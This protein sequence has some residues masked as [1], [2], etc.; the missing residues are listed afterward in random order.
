MTIHKGNLFVKNHIRKVLL[1]S[2]MGL[3]LTFHTVNAHSQS[4]SLVKKGSSLNDILKELR[5]T[6]GYDFFYPEGLINST[7]KFDLTIKNASIN[8]VLDKVLKPNALDYTITKN[9]VVIKPGVAFRQQTL[10]QGKV[11]DEEGKPIA[12][13]TVTHLESKSTTTTDG[14]GVFRFGNLP[15]K[16]KILISYLGYEKRE[17]AAAANMGNIVLKTSSADLEA[18]EINVGYGR[19]K[20]IDLT[21][22]VTR[23]TETELEGAPPHAD[24]A[25]MIQGKAAGVNVMVANGAP[26]AGVS[27]MIRG[28]TSL[29]GN[30]QPLWVIDGVPQYNVNNND[31]G[32]LLYDYNINDIESVDIL[33]DASST[34]IYGSRAANGVIIVTTKSGKKFKKPQIDISYNQGIQVQR[35]NFRTLNNDEFK[36]VVT[37]AARNFFATTGAKGTGAMLTLIDE[38]KVVPGVEVDYFSAPFLS[39]AFFDGQTNWWQELTRNAVERKL[40]VSL[41][42]G[43]EASNYYISVGVPQ[44]DGIIKGSSRRGFS[45]RINLDSKIAN[46]FL[47]GLM[48]NGSN[49]DINNKDNMIDKIWNF[50][51]DF[52]MYTADGKIFDPGYNEES[53][54]TSLKNKDLSSRKGL[55]GSTFIQFTPIKNLVLKSNV[56][57]NYN[58]TVTDRFAREGTVNSTHK[59][60]ANISQS[61]SSNWAFENTVK[62]TTLLNRIHD[63][64]LLGGFSMERGSFKTFATGVQ[65]FPDQDIMTNLTSGT[66]P[67]KPTSNNYSTAMVSAFTRLNYKLYDRYL[68]TFTF[69]ADGSS[70]FGP[71]KR[72]GLFPSGA[73]AWILSKEGFM[74]NVNADVFNLLKLRG[75]YGVSGSQVLGNNDWRT[76]YGAAQF[77]EQPGFAPNQLGNADLRWEET[78]TKEIAFDYGFFKN[79]LSGSI[80]FYDKLTS[81]IIYNKSIP[82]SSAF[83]SVKQNIATIQNRGMEFFIDYNVFRKKDMSLSLNFNIAHNKSTVEKINGVDKFLDL[84]AGNAL[85]IRMQEGQPMGQWY[86]FKWSGRY[87]QS[88][89][90]YNLLSSMNPTTGAKIWY[91]N[92]LGS[93]RPG[94]LKFEDVNKDGIVNNDDMVPLGTSQPDYFGGFGANFRKGNLSLTLNFTYSTG[95]LRYWY[96]NTQ[97]WY[98]NGLYLRNYPDYVL[99]SWSPDNRQS[100]W[101]RMSYG[102]GSSNTFSDYWLSKANYLKLSQVRINYRVPDKWAQR[103]LKGGLDFSGSVSN[104]FVLTNYNGI[105]PEGNFRLAGGATGMGTDFGTYPTIR[106]FNLSVRYSLK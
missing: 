76:L 12:G 45:G 59:G 40:D 72:W 64:D 7:N 100:E 6:Y 106:S 73:V 38:T 96:T 65:N 37:D 4:I 55:N 33:K 92:G 75:S 10:I 28:N 89:E 9:I 39:T 34:A 3:V 71:D 95:S 41:R 1:L 48:L 104:V 80:G 24:I 18:V 35:D 90:E 43:T 25:S 8:E 36:A 79:K 26:G 83:I 2:L 44:Q 70:R 91:Q 19:R 29:T 53:P 62:Y 22:S 66:T 20:A 87:Y 21:G 15:V 94:D 14:Q 23:I 56:S 81:D 60:Q 101:P 52:P 11:L 50:R 32:Q 103:N 102:Q 47:I 31:V 97:N 98:V 5:A 46:N 88:M 51:P 16:G 68:A 67:L 63:L 86:G 74:K 54:L 61:E 13:A 105:D 30:S 93:I 27:V 84:Y 99:N 49:S 77:D 17:V 57:I 42:G 58:Q 85:A 78:L 69:R 82:S